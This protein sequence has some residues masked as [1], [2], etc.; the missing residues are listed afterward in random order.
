MSEFNFA[1][2][3]AE[4][5][6]AP[7]G[8][9]IMAREAPAGRIL[10][11]LKAP[12][13]FDL[14][15]L[16]FG[17]SGLDLNWFRDEFAKE[18]PAFSL[19][20]NRR[21]CTVLAAAI[22]GG[23]IS[24]G[25]SVAILAVVTASTSGK[26]EVTEAGWLLETAQEALL[27][28]AVVSRQPA[29]IEAEVNIPA[30]AKLAEEISAQAAN[31]WPNLITNLGKVRAEAQAATK[32][33]AAQV[34]TT[35]DAIR[36]Q[37]ALSREETQML[38]WLFGEHSRT[39]KRHFSTLAPGAVAIFSGIELGDL[40]TASVFGPIAAP[41]MLERMLRLTKEKVKKQNLGTSLSS[42]S[43]TEF[44]ALKTFGRDQPSR[45]FPIM[46]AIELARTNQRAWREAFEKAT[47]LNPSI[48]FNPIELA[49]QVYYE[50]L[51]GRIL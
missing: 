45:I 37:L 19:I 42:I 49:T 20:N 16:Y 2:R 25:E 51:L 7:G 9:I 10:Q 22:L 50:H 39:L 23:A 6:L 46:T 12:R 48:E 3:Y 17:H 1:D 32:S 34:S 5:G 4:A 28:E 15:G 27:R 33:V 41:A 36:S 44:Q 14:V 30:A 38:W 11:D 31:D 24:R 35:L 18:D 43:S 47:D 21:E 13:I 29:V 40:T 8:A 26:R